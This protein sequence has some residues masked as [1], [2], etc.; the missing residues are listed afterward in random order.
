MTAWT[1]TVDLH[2][3][4]PAAEDLQAAVYAGL[5]GRPRTLPAKFFYDAKGSALFEQ[6]CELPEYYLTRTELA[7][8]D[9]D[10][11]AMADRIGP[12]ALLIEL[13]S[14]AGT[15][16]RRLLEALDRPA[17]YMPI[18]I[19]RSALLD[20]ADRLNRRFEDL[21]I[22]AVCADYVAGFDLPDLDVDPAKRV[23]YFP[24]S[25]L[26]NLH[27]AQARQLFRTMRDL[28]GDDGGLLLGVDMVKSPDVLVPAYDDAKGVTS[29][30]NLNLLTRINREVG[31]DFDLGHW[32]HRA[33][34]NPEASRMESY[35]VSDRPQD[36]RIGSK[37]FAFAKGESIWTESSYKYTL[38]T[39]Q[40]LASGFEL[41]EQWQDE[42][43]WFSVMYLRA[44]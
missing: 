6:I 40:Q 21:P 15:K 12:E 2:D 28:A 18:D 25:T 26:G 27:P 1:T 42:Q 17:G 37:R 30:F 32:S 36:V 9:R 19:S 8:M 31:G 35:L 39:V 14:G 22:H 34:W 7:I 38:E 5:S 33:Q 20:S 13:G 43:G 4:E 41:V 29:A 23:V 10:L 3:L 16:T 11:P 24:G 44:V